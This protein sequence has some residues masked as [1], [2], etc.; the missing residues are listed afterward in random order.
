MIVVKGTDLK[1]EGTI[2]EILEEVLVAVVG[3]ALN[4]KE[5]GLPEGLVE[6][7]INDLAKASIEQFKIASLKGVRSTTPN[8]N[9]K[10]MN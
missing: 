7:W 4:L 6:Q 10:E 2:E 9:K 1:I 3:T 5:E 8:D